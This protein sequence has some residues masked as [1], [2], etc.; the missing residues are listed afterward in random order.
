MTLIICSL[1]SYNLIVDLCKFL[2][3]FFFRNAVLG[4][5]DCCESCFLMLLVFPQGTARRDKTDFP[6]M[7]VQLPTDYST[8]TSIITPE[9]KAHVMHHVSNPFIVILRHIFDRSAIWSFLCLE[10]FL[11]CI[12]PLNSWYFCLCSS[13]AKIREFSFCRTE[14]F[15][16]FIPHSFSSAI[17]RSFFTYQNPSFQQQHCNFRD[18][19]R[20]KEQRWCRIMV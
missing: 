7:P 1:I 17:L 15:W 9:K 16:L 5:H 8:V 20:R 10:P 11:D 12:G 18:T 6:S 3:F 13:T 4:E 14:I 2:V 19:C